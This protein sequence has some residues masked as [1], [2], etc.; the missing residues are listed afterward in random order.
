MSPFPVQKLKIDLE[1]DSKRCGTCQHTGTWEACISGSDAARLDRGA[2]IILGRKLDQFIPF[3]DF[4]GMIIVFQRLYEERI[5]CRQK[6]GWVHLL[7]CACT[8]WRP[9]GSG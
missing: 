4:V 3:E 8:L 1:K 6:Q 2:K 7:D 9:R 5:L